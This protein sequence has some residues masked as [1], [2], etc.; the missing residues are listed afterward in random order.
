M[1]RSPKSP[2]KCP[3]IRIYLCECLGKGACPYLPALLLL[4]L[5]QPAEGNA[6]R[7]AATVSVPRHPS[8][9]H[10]TSS[11]AHARRTYVGRDVLGGSIP[12]GA[13][14]RGAGEAPNKRSR[15]PA[16]RHAPSALPQPPKRQRG[17]IAQILFHA[18]PNSP[19]IRSGKAA[20]H[21]Y[22]ANKS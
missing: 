18:L 11:K 10:P 9:E 3:E 12:Q 14:A 8:R 20:M 15:C 21:V 13:G 19:H 7:T 1:G 2:K 4:P 5:L 17:P 22:I 6:F 16:E